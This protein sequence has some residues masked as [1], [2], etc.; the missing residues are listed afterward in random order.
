[1]QANKFVAVFAELPY[2]LIQ[3]DIVDDDG[4]DPAR[5]FGNEQASDTAADPACPSRYDHRFIVQPTTF[6]FFTDFSPSA[7]F[8]QF[9]AAF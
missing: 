1:M 5:I 7:F 4:Y 8:L 3:P 2:G 9:S 6:H